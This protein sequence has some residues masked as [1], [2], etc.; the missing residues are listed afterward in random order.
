MQKKF[1][2]TGMA[3]LLILGLVGCGSNSNHNS[4]ETQEVAAGHSQEMNEE[5]ETDEDAL[6]DAGQE[7]E[8]SENNKSDEENLE[9]EEELEEEVSDD[10]EQEESEF[11]S[12]TSPEYDIEK[13]EKAGEW[14]EISAEYPVFG[15]E[16]VDQ[17][18]KQ[19]AEKHFKEFEAEFEENEKQLEGYSYPAGESLYFGEPTV[20]DAYVSFMFAQVM[21]LGGPHPFFYQHPFNYDVNNQR[22]LTI[23]D[24]VKNKTELSNLGD[25][26]YHKLENEGPEL[27]KLE[28][29]TQPEW[30]NFRHF[31]LTEDSLVFHYEHY[32]LGPYAYGVF[33]VEVTFDELNEL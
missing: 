33:D 28:E 13:I 30:D 6:G 5:V 25:L 12:P 19:E 9:A 14:I 31:V 29:A 1:I 2:I 22:E 20:T 8:E 27:D 15:M 10:E 23:R 21:N 18:I 17:V 26:I 32:V 24:F 16:E 3:I 11:Q 7:G 4:K